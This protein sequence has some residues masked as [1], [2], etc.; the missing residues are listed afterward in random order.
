MEHKEEVING[1]KYEVIY[2]PDVPAGAYIVVG[3]PEGMVDSLWASR[4]FPVPEPFATNLHNILYD[5]K[6]FT[7]KDIARNNIVTGV[8]QEAFSIDAQILV[9]AFANFEKESV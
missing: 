6:I 2:S 3:P 7:Y 8:L 5:R 4:G 1:R 9:E